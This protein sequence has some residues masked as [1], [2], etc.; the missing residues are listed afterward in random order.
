LD[1]REERKIKILIH[2]QDAALVVE[3]GPPGLP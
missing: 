1:V 3:I 2:I